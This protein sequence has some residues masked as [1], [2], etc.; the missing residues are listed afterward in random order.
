[1]KEVTIKLHGETH[2][3][4]IEKGFYQVKLFDGSTM[5]LHVNEPDDKDIASRL[6][7]YINQL[8]K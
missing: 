6:N 7:D 8:K 5:E 3:I 4:F 1:M 2:K